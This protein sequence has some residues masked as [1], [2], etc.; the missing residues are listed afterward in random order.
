MARRL[1]QQ[2]GLSSTVK[3]VHSL[4]LSD[5]FEC[6]NRILASQS[7]KGP[8]GPSR[9]KRGHRNLCSLYRHK[10]AGLISDASR[11]ELDDP[12]ICQ[13]FSGN[14]SLNAQASQRRSVFELLRLRGFAK[15]GTLVRR[16]H[17]YLRVRVR[18]VPA[19]SELRRVPRASEALRAMHQRAQPAL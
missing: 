1:L 11:A 8:A 9:S 12:T 14:S 19:R 18:P 2:V 6:D 7:L 15:P 10:I 13:I 4:F 5:F 16:G 17:A 3:F